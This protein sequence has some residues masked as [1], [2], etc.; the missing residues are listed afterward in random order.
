MYDVFISFKNL[1]R[2]GAP[3]RDSQIAAQLHSALGHAGIKAFFSNVEIQRSGDAR[4][5]R[6]IDS[7]LQEARVIIV[8]GTC[9]EHISSHWVEYEWR[10]FSEQ[11]HCGEDKH[12]LTVLEGILPHRLPPAFT[13]TQSYT[14]D[15]IPT[16]VDKVLRILGRSSFRLQNSTVTK[17]VSPEAA[18]TERKRGKNDC[19]FCGNFV[20]PGKGTCPVCGR[21]RREIECPICG[22]RVPD[23]TAVCPVCKYRFRPDGN[24]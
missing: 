4:W 2:N 16:V 20:P 19:D 23:G 7:A 15:C 8:V 11:I 14:P 17:P 5:G 3:T 6:L 24:R 13:Q 22:M 12:I 9:C 10:Y 18:L 21:K 1:D